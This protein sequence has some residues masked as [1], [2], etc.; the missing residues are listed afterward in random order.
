MIIFDGNKKSSAEMKQLVI[1]EEQT[2]GD[3]IDSE[4]FCRDLKIKNEYNGQTKTGKQYTE[5]ELLPVSAAQALIKVH[6]EAVLKSMV[7]VVCDVQEVL[8][9]DTD[10]II[11]KIVELIDGKYHIVLKNTASVQGIDTNY[12]FDTLMLKVEAGGLN[13]KG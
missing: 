1:D 13:V 12:K 3:K 10:N 6:Q 9:Q 8:V 11:G 4:W 2:F 7:P 5:L